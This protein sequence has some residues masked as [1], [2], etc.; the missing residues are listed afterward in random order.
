MKLRI[1]GDSLRLR[2]TRSEVD[3]IASGGASEN[4]M[5]FGPDREL[6]YRLE[7]R[8]YGPVEASFDQNLLSVYLPES[9]AARWTGSEQVSIR[10]EQA[11]PGGAALS[12]LVEKDFECLEPRPGEDSSNLFEN[13]LKNS[14]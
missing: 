1:Q 14:V 4:V 11:L 8:A 13:P 3:A 6:R 2:L 5:R 7:V 9:E 10:A 12:I